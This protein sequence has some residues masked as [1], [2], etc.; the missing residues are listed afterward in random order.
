MTSTSGRV[1]FDSTTL[2]TAIYDACHSRLQLDFRDGTRYAYAG[3]TP[4]LFRDLLRATSKGY[5]F[6]R[7]IRGRFLYVKLGPKN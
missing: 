1:E 2:A 5:Y 3:I 7:Y 4:E 6:N